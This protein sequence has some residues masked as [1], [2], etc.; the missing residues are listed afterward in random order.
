MAARCSP[1]LVL[2]PARPR[3]RLGFDVRDD[4][5][6]DQ[7]KDGAE[8][9]DRLRGRGKELKVHGPED[10]GAAPKKGAFNP[11]GRR[12]RHLGWP[13]PEEGRPAAPLKDLEWQNLKDQK[14]LEGFR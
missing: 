5:H 13:Q 4:A 3:F 9:G 1:E 7:E 11:F 8:N 10:G 12:L 6:R 2:A 14:T